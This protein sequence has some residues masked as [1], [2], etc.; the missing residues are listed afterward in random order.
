[1][2]GVLVTSTFSASRKKQYDISDR[3]YVAVA[4]NL[5]DSVI[6]PFESISALGYP[7]APQLFNV[8]NAAYRSTRGSLYMYPEALRWNSSSSLAVQ[9][10]GGFWPKSKGREKAMV[11]GCCV[12]RKGIPRCTDPSRHTIIS[13]IQVSDTIR[14]TTS[15][16]SRTSVTHTGLP[17][18]VMKSFYKS[19]DTQ[20]VALHTPE[21][22]LTM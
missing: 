14:I 3:A 7:A 22:R 8:P 10:Y 20:T 19:R 13:K 16:E 6:C 5:P 21:I 12:G 11:K 1:M 15:E 9:K 17:K 18:E 2:P 4:Y